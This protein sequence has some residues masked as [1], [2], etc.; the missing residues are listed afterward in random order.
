MCCM[1]SGW[2]AYAQLRV[3][4]GLLRVGHCPRYGCGLW[5]GSRL[6]MCPGAC[7][8]AMPHGRL[9]LPCHVTLMAKVEA[10]AVVRTEALRMQAKLCAQG[11]VQHSNH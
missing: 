4:L 11:A 3:A 8:G 1:P 5:Q 6:C 10:G 2:L 9:G 7:V